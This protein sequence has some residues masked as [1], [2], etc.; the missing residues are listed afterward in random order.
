MAQ[1]VRF[2]IH[3]LTLGLALFAFMETQGLMAFGALIGVFV[4][5]CALA[6]MVFRRLATPAEVKADLEE[7]LRGE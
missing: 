1:W 2:A 6:E 3:L 4:V 7:R 5:G